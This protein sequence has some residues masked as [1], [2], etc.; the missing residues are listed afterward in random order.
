MRTKASNWLQRLQLLAVGE[1]VR[2]AT[3]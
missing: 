1:L 2:T 3:L